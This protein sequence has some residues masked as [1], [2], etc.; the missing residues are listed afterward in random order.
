M[1]FGFSIGDIIAISTL[2]NT[3][4]K[5]FVDSPNEFRVVSDEVKSLSNVLRD[6]E[7][8]FPERSLN[9]RQQADL[10]DY[11]KGCDHVLKDLDRILDRYHDL[12]SATRPSKLGKK[13]RRLWKR[14]KWEPDD[15][16][17]LRSRLTSNVGLLNAFTTTLSMWVLPS[18][19]SPNPLAPRKTSMSLEATSKKHIFC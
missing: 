4:R 19:N 11:I 12:D 6:L 18:V 15:V 14:L 8:I 17:E 13:P 16:K 9:E 1:S 3:V 2:T 5:R 10:K 7:D